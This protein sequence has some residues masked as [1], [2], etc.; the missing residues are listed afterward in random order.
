MAEI[1]V[2]FMVPM[3]LDVCS[4]TCRMCDHRDMMALGKVACK[5]RA[6]TSF[7]CRLVVLFSLR[8]EVSQRLLCGKNLL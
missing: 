8:P 2:E 3:S 4:L 6:V 1:Q 7:W 5:R